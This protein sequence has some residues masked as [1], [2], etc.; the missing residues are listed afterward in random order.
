MLEEFV[1]QVATQ[2]L[3]LHGAAVMQHGEKLEEYRWA[4]DVPYEL[5]SL[6]K[7]FTSMAIGLLV[8]AGKLRLDDAA[9]SFFPR[10][11]LPEVISPR[12]QA[13]T[14]RNLLTMA[15]G[16][17]TSLMLSPQRRALTTSDW[18]RY[19]FSVA[20]D[21]EPGERFVYD[22]GCTY[23]LSAIIQNI[24]GQKTRDYLIPR[25]FEP[26]GM[27]APR[28]DECPL[29]I[30][31]GGWGLWLRTDEVLR[32]GQLLLQKGVWEGQRLIPEDWIDQAT[33][34]Q[35]DTASF[36][37]GADN[38]VGY[39]YQFWMNTVGGYRAD[40]AFAQYSIVLPEKDAVIAINAHNENQPV[41]DAVWQTILPQL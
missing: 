20:Q 23:I 31:A 2:G 21:L 22:S 37:G 1:A 5:H 32:F 3:T 18:V 4:P 15:P 13:L 14:V 16:H 9:I 27:G 30:T 7:S 25:L 10:E 33:S 29:G 6:S 19:Y 35:I 28:W 11:K 34:R 17:S 24:T 8:E 26:M 38:Y 39:G 40:G 36:S 41:L 12:L